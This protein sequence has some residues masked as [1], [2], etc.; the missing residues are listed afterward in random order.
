MLESGKRIDTACFSLSNFGFRLHGRISF[1]Y[2]YTYSRSKHYRSLFILVIVYHFIRKLA[3][4]NADGVP[5][6]LLYNIAIP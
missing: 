2:G 4:P 5:L 3:F 1:A 6:S